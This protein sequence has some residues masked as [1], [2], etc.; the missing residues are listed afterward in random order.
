MYGDEEE[1]GQEQDPRS[2]NNNALVSQVPSAPK[3]TF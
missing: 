2:D 3:L 1:Y